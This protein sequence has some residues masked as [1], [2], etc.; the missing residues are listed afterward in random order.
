M[1]T[2]K[3]I[4]LLIYLIFVG[5]NTQ[6]NKTNPVVT[7]VT[8]ELFFLYY[9]FLAGFRTH[10]D[11]PGSAVLWYFLLVMLVFLILASVSCACYAVLGLMFIV[12]CYTRC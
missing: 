9:V 10:R 7:N 2:F 1:H 12:K 4:H 8:Q 11:L 3:S 6:E 5:L